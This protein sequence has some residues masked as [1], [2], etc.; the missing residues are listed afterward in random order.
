MSM[1]VLVALVGEDKVADMEDAEVRRLC[2]A[3]DMEILK[4]DALTQRLLGAVQ[5]AAH[6]MS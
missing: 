3:I 6:G 5:E 1:K 4:D 2:D